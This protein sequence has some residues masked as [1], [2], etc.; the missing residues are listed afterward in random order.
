[1]ESVYY[2][3]KAKIS[4]RLD[5]LNYKCSTVCTSVYVCKSVKFS[6]KNQFVAAISISNI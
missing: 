6:R 1:M 4:I 5:D 2:Y 3:W